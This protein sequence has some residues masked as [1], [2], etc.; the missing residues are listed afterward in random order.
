MD[1]EVLRTL[2]NGN[3]QFVIDLSRELELGYSVPT[4]A[5]HISHVFFSK[6]CYLNYDRFL[7]LAASIFIAL[8][9][10]DISIPIKKLCNAFYSVII[11]LNKS[12]D[13]YN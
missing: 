5:M 4:L 12:I 7:V 11:R 8:K 2:A 3:V 1:E 6:M 10:K 9:I 13:P